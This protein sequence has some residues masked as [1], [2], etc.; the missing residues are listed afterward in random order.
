MYLDTLWGFIGSIDLVMILDSMLNR[1]YYFV[2]G[3]KPACA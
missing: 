1:S 3:V 2:L